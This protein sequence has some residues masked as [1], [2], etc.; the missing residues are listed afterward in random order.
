[1]TTKTHILRVKPPW[2][3]GGDRRRCGRC[4]VDEPPRNRA[5]Y[6]RRDAVTEADET[7]AAK[8]KADWRASFAKTT[9]T[10][11]QIICVRDA[12]REVCLPCWQNLGAYGLKTWRTD[13]LEVLRIDLAVTDDAGR[14]MLA[15]ELI[16]IADLVAAYP[17]EFRGMMDSEAV[18]Q[19]LAGVGQ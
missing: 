12:A 18:L 1:V 16:A 17:G 10:R 19:A 5:G 15:K 3:D 14:R 6:A 7:M 9:H 11:P 13:P 8:A 4:V 2:R